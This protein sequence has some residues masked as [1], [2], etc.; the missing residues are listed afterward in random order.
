MPPVS[1]SKPIIPFKNVE[2]TSFTPGGPSIISFSRKKFQKKQNRFCGIQNPLTFAPPYENGAAEKRK[3][4][5]D[6]RMKR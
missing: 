2:K 6:S 3:E 4:K 1:G 5:G